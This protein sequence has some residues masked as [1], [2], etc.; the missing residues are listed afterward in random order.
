M[1]TLVVCLVFLLVV[2]SSVSEFT[3][4]ENGMLSSSIVT[5]TLTFEKVPRAFFLVRG[6][7]WVLKSQLSVKFLRFLRYQLK[8]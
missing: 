1:N 2:E 3:A 4:F 8:F 7:G 6:S 5:K